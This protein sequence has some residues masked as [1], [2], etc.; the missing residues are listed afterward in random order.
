MAITQVRIPRFSEKRQLSGTLILAFFAIYVVWGSTFF[1]I[2]VLVQTVPPLFA[3]G[4]R[5]FTAG[6]I[7][8]GISRLRGVE[9]PSMKEWRNLAT[10]GALMFLV[11]YSALF[12]AEKTVP[13]G[14]AAVLVATLPL[15]TML[16]E[17]LVFR[18]EPL[19]TKTALAIGLGFTGVAILTWNPGHFPFL[20]CLAILGGETGWAT[21][22]V[23]SS[24]LQLPKSRAITA[25]AQMALG[26]L[27]LLI[28]SLAAG[29]L[30]TLPHFTLPAGLALLYL[31]V[32]G[33]LF[34]F[35]AFVWLLSRMPATA[36]SSHAYVNPV[37]ALALGHW[38]A[39]E[40]FSGRMLVGGLLILVSVAVILRLRHAAH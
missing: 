17:T 12:W 13:S 18:R 23:L 32:F 38:F 5:F 8:Y 11:T 39:G 22:A 21:G 3:A 37:V 6:V 2:R 40:I 24:Q 28:C 7:L 36:V 31:I 19:H 35:T 16:L 26:G 20:P 25:G 34:A 33:S 29:E 9:P 27:M 1:A 4:A 30:R 15:I 10:L 14:I